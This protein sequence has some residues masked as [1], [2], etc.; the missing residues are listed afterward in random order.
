MHI[1]HA[2]IAAGFAEPIRADHQAAVASN[3]VDGPKRER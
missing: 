3:T 1:G 2:E